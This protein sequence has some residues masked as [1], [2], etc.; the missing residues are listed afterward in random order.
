MIRVPLESIKDRHKNEQVILLGNGP[1]LW[2]Y[3][4]RELPYITIGLNVSWRFK[5]ARYHCCLDESHVL[6]Y[7]AGR[8]TPMCGYIM[9]V[10]AFKEHFE[11][12]PYTVMLLGEMPL[13][14]SIFLWKESWRTH[15]SDGAFPYITG[16]FGIQLALYMGFTT[17]WLLGYDS[18]PERNWQHRYYKH[19]WKEIQK[20]LPNVE[21][22]NCNPK[23]LI[24]AFPVK[25]QRT[26]LAA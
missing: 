17:L 2:K 1:T 14:P 22:Y 19:A 18:S 3:N 21:I 8:Y 4:S 13:V 9:T 20:D 10:E 5:R 15:V 23:T 25:E 24:K 26:W 6:D 11:T 12:K 16:L 7:I